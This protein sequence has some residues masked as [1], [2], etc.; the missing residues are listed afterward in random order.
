MT[1]NEAF[2]SIRKMLEELKKMNNTPNLPQKFQD[3]IECKLEDIDDLLSKLEK[4]T[5]KEIRLNQ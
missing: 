3:K 4:A 2:D 5:E 1:Y